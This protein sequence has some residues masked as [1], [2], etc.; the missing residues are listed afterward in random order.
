VTGLLAAGFF[1]PATMA[2][3]AISKAAETHELIVAVDGRRTSDVI[4]FEEAIEN[5]GPGEAV[6]LTVVR[7]GERQQIRLA[8]PL[9]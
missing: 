6:Y 1:P 9:R 7:R 2:V 4:D 3:M 8:L 5:A